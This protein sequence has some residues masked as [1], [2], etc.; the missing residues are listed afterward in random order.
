MTGCLPTAP[1]GASHLERFA[2]KK[3][4]QRA[5]NKDNGY[6]GKRGDFLRGCSKD[7]PALSTT[8]AFHHEIFFVSAVCMEMILESKGAPTIQARSFSKTRI[9]YLLSRYPAISHTFFLKEV[10]GLKQLGFPIG[11]CSINAPDRSRD[12][13]TAV[14]AEE[15]DQTCYIKGGDHW[16]N[17]STLL[18]VFF[19]HPRVCLRGLRVALSLFTFDVYR[20]LYLCLYLL[21]AL[22]LGD[23][24]K[25]RKLDHLHVHFGGSV[26]T[27][28]FLAS[29]AWGF[30]YSLTIHGPEEFYDVEHYYLAQKFRDAQFIFCI[31]NFCRS[32]VMKYCPPSH[33]K[34]LHVL[35]LGVDPEHFRSQP[36]TG[37]PILQ[38][39]SVGRLTPA[40]GHIILL[41]SLVSLLQKGHKIHLTLIGD[42]SE[43]GLLE[44]FASRQQLTPHVTLLG[45]LNHDQTRARLALADVFVLPS[46]AEGVP[47]A[48][49]EAMAMEIPCVSTLIAGIPELIQNEVEGLLVSA[50]SS[51]ELAAAME[52][53]I[54]S[55]DLRRQL[56]SA[57]RAKVMRSYNLNENISRLAD[58][59]EQCLSTGRADA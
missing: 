29:H 15:A 59:F 11:T 35:R 41:Q 22:L 14:E 9:A 24:M 23:W 27:V 5:K 4:R 19:S 7:I 45:A 39:I 57:A 1:D 43:R 30:P 2:L 44:D 54:V 32:Q 10:L 58:A 51:E 42:G 50:S 31:S 13:L 20:C 18:S 38:I 28:G 17:I 48:L 21:E 16:R 46:F 55:P 33:W 47:V 49:M 40:K 12:L 25:R 36:R 8:D 34:N 3:S 6:Y 52:R 53:L 37:D 26:A 56:G